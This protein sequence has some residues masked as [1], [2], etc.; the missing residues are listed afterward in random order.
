MAK[1]PS[2][3]LAVAASLL[4][5]SCDKKSNAQPDAAVVADAAPDASVDAAVVDLPAPAIDTVEMKLNGTRVTLVNP[6]FCRNG[7]TGIGFERTSDP[8]NS[9]PTLFLHI[10]DLSAS[11]DIL[12]KNGGPWHMDID[13]KSDTGSLVWGAADPGCRATIVETTATVVELKATD[14]ALKNQ[15]GSQTGM[16]SF[17]VRCTRDD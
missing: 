13:D 5:P 11:G 7:T 15:F 10:V 8:Q 9:T 17:R 4:L 2:T 12:I 1:L 3:I 14:C 16:V 6:E